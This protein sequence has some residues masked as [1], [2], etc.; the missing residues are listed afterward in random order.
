MKLSASLVLFSNNP[1]EYGM[2]MQSFLD[3]C[4]G[5]LYVVDNSSSPLSHALFAHPRVRYIYAGVNLGFGKAHNLAISM[6]SGTSE[7]HLLLN[8]D[9]VFKPHVMPELTRFLESNP[10]VGA[11]MPRINYPDGS[12]QHLCKLLPTPMDLIFRRFFPSKHVRSMINQRY[13]MHALPQDRPS[14][15]PNLSGC[16]LLIRTQVLQK[17]GGFDERYFMYM[18][19]VDLV[20]R[21]G[22]VAETVYLPSVQVVHAYAKGSYQNRK[23]FGFHIRSALLYF[24]KWGWLYDQTR[25][26]RN[27]AAL[28]RLTKK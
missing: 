22:D 12:L 11:L 17:L 28:Q 7:A 2:A 23:L 5:T 16:F 6:A 1:D 24:F 25:H 14:F 10:N 9:I 15:I 26:E 21:I 27:R 19:D 20:R 13:E 4:D 8:P 18:E 3:S